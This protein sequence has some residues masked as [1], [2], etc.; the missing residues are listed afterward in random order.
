MFS[1][2]FKGFATMVVVA[3]VAMLSL[4]LVSVPSAQAASSTVVVYPGDQHGWIFLDDQNDATATATATGKF[5]NGPSNPPLGTGSVELTTSGPSDGQII[6]LPAV[7]QG[8]KL[9]DITTLKYSTYQ[10]TTNTSN[11][12]AIALQ[13]DV[14][15]DVTDTDNL[16]QGRVVFEPYNNNNGVTVPLGVWT[17]WDALIG[18]WWLSK[19]HVKFSDNCLQSSPCTLTQL[20]NL[21]PNIGIHPTG[22]SVLFKAGSGWTAFSGNVDALTIGVSTNTTIYNFELTPPLTNMS[23]CK[24]GGWQTVKRSDG[25][26]FK[27]QG[28]CVSY[29]NNG[30]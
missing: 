15:K 17:E 21:Y 2:K 19:S 14:D 3:L 10:A 1:N 11:V 28:D 26:S 5:V 24:D 16:Y 9:A 4:G 13:F 22:G 23:Q 7:Y 30:K 29:T 12:L 6:K 25:S 8:V 20:I 18:K 27:N